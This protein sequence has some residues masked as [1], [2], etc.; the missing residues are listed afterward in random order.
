[1]PKQLQQLD[2]ADILERVHGLT[3]DEYSVFLQ[4]MARH[5]E[6]VVLWQIVKW[7]GL[8]LIPTGFIL[9]HATGVGLYFFFVSLGAFSSIHAHDRLRFRLQPISFKAMRILY[10]IE[11][12]RSR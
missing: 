10:E 4:H 7:L 5:L 8:I 12:E 6:L 2:D 1:M 3:A 11:K 9:G